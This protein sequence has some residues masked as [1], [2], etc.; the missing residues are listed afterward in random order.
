[1]W[2]EFTTAAGSRKQELAQTR[3]ICFYF[4]YVFFKSMS[5]REMA[6]TFKKDH[7]TV[8]HSISVV[9]RDMKVDGVFK[10]KME[11]YHERI[12]A[13]LRR[14]GLATDQADKMLEDTNKVITNMRVIAEAYCQLT[15]RKMVDM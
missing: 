15:G 8:T 6:E 5:Y 1:M 12:A 7:S 4:G 13:A 3:Q 11:A 14:A 9:Q 10:R 2:E